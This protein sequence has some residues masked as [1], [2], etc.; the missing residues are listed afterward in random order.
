MLVS[1]LEWKTEARIGDD[2]LSFVYLPTGDRLSVLTRLTGYGD[3]NIFDT[4][5][6]YKDL[7]GKFWLASGN[8]DIREHGKL[9]VE[10]AVD[11]VKAHANNCTG[12]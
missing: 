3:G 1:E 6:G 8:K 4:E 7:E 9:T 10:E 2:S 5:T 11:W 12:D